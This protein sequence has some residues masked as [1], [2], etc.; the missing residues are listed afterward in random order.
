M[1]RRGELTGEAWG[2]IAPLLPASGQRGGPWLDHRR[3]IHG[4]LWK[5]RIDCIAGAAMR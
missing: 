5:L 4:I 3:V 1:V 2:L